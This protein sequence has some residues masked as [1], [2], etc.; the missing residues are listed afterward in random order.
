MQLEIIASVCAASA[1]N[2]TVSWYTRD[3]GMRVVNPFSIFWWTGFL[4]ADYSVCCLTKLV[5]WVGPSFLNIFCG[6]TLL[7][8]VYNEKIICASASWL[9]AMP[10]CSRAYDSYSSLWKN[11][12]KYERCVSSNWQV[13]SAVLSRVEAY[14]ARLYSKNP[15]AFLDLSLALIFL[16]HRG[17]PKTSLRG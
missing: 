17:V 13:I 2:R 15:I 3:W 6:S 1:V 12:S 8:S 7:T 4:R 10:F 11:F 16:I 9:F 14:N 5:S